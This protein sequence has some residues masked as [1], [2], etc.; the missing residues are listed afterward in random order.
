MHLTEIRDQRLVNPLLRG[1]LTPYSDTTA[2][3]VDSI[4][5]HTADDSPALMPGFVTGR[6]SVLV[7]AADSAPLPVPGQWA[8]MPVTPNLISW[9]IEML[10][11]KAVRPE[12]IAW[13]T[14]FTLPPNTAFWSYYA[15]GTYQN[16]AVFSPH[17]SWAQPGSYVFRLTSLDTRRLHDGVYRLVVTAADERG[18]HSSSSVVFCIHNRPG[19]AG[20]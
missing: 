19:W 15:R 12:R 18:N 3:H 6:V 16:M 1:H 2:P 20:V 8:D 17:Y 7:R 4:S 5:F 13:D 14:R 10:G 11:G 9:R